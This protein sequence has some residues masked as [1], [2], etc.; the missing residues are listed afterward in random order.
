MPHM[1]ARP[2]YHAAAAIGKPPP[3]SD[4]D[5][6]LRGA[7]RVRSIRAPGPAPVIGP[8][9]AL[10]GIPAG[11][12]DAPAD[13][14]H[15]RYVLLLVAVGWAVLMARGRLWLA[16]LAGTA[17]LEIVLVFWIASFG[18]PYGV[19]VDPEI[20]RRAADAAVA[21]VGGDD[22]ALAGEPLHRTPATWL[23]RRAR[24]PDL[25]LAL[26]TLL[27]LLI[28]PAL[29]LLVASAPKPRA[30][31]LL[32]ASLWLAFSTAQGEAVRGAGFLPGLWARPVA[33]VALVALV[34]VALA[35]GRALRPWV[36][37]ACGLLLAGAWAFVPPAGPPLPFAQRLLVA[38]ADQA[39]WLLLGGWGLLRGAPGG[40]L[41]LTVGGAAA[42]LVLPLVGP[43][44]AWGA[45]ALCRLG[46]ILAAAGPLHRLLQAAVDGLGHGRP[47]PARLGKREWA[48]I[49]ALILAGVPG[50][51]AARWD[52]G[53]LD[54]VAYASREPLSR[55]LAPAFQ[56]LRE[57]VPPGVTCMASPDYAPMVAVLAQR[58]VLRAPTLGEPAD[59]QRR[60]RVERMLLSGRE[61][62]LLRRYQVGCLVFLD[63]D[64]GWLGILSPSELAGVPGLT[65]RFA[66]AHAHVYAVDP[67]SP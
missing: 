47:W 33:S 32:A 62:N 11:L 15:L 53:N 5:V 19:L 16:V 67:R 14:I 52:P 29:A 45:Q 38:T 23:A 9:G 28:V 22:G 57:N 24:T 59:D 43:A 39:P 58:R 26:P 31:A 60:R 56:W 50:S 46:L 40:A 48:G 42:L 49:A 27:P 51:F 12:A 36:E 4:R 3:T 34:A 41:A 21:S 64:Q 10:L 17:F 54:T 13:V 65:L 37:V 44:D 18:R 2:V 66:D 63:G 30:E 7:A 35:P 1:R 20:T 6:S 61:P 55:N 25:A 8:P